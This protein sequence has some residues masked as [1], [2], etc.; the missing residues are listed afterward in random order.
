MSRNR[1]I[2]NVQDVYIGSLPDETE[3]SI[4]GAEGYQVL[5]RI[6]RVQSFSYDIKSDVVRESALG[7]SS[8][9]SKSYHVPTAVT[10][11]LDYINYGIN[12]ENRFGFNTLNEGK[13]IVDDI[14]T[15]NG[16]SGRNLYLTI[17]EIDGSDTHGDRTDYPSQILSA[18]GFV[19]E[20]V[21]DPKSKNYNVV[22]IQNTHI[23][24]Y[25]ISASVGELVR[26]S[27]SFEGDNMIGYA[28][29]SGINIPYLDLKKG[30]VTDN[31]VGVY[32]SD[33]SAGTDGWG[34]N[35]GNWYTSTVG[36][37]TEV[38]QSVGNTT[39]GGHDLY[40]QYMLTVGKK[41][42]IS[43]K[44]YIKESATAAI[45]KG[46]SIYLGS[47]G[48]SS[49]KYHDTK[50]NGYIP[51]DLNTWVDFEVELVANHV[52]LYFYPLD[53]NGS[54]S[55]AATTSDYFAIKDIVVTDIT[56]AKE[57]IV[58]NTFH[59][60]FCEE[61]QKLLLKPGNIS[62]D[63]SKATSDGI[64]FHNDHVQEISINL[65]IGRSNQRHVGHKMTSFKPVS[66]PVT[67]GLDMN[68]IVKDS[69]TGSFLDNAKPEE[70]YNLVIKLNDDNSN[71]LA[72]YTFSGAVLEG[73]GNNHTLQGNRTSKMNFKTDIDL[74]NQSKGLFLSGVVNNVCAN[75]ITNDGSKD[76]TDDDG[77]LIIVK[78]VFYPK[79]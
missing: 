38:L 29:G 77:N 9:L 37:E 11:K 40:R 30:E 50:T 17:N 41:Y 68:M 28:S 20:E 57:F 24:N 47:G 78:S 56:E 43:G 49:Q 34:Q 52:N 4:T 74:E 27:V 5:Q 10:A 55:F 72:A 59:P 73:A 76:V 75:V 42:K 63:I 36:G 2:Y 66:F 61:D 46:V 45:Y 18:T 39:E 26:T 53:T 64:L 69:V 79:Y 54:S 44:F 8:A 25:N 65:D 21:I 58:P 51:I 71:V 31:T 14:I 23:K 19:P 1:I 35:N 12:N 70:E 32:T 67:V 33:F 22:V 7:R 62:L 13:G 3:Y 60:S 15:S 16:V 6:D 48:N